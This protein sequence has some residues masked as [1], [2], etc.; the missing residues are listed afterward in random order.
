MTAEELAL[1]GYPGAAPA[2]DPASQP[3]VTG[4]D[5]SMLNQQPGSMPMQQ[6]GMMMPPGMDAATLSSFRGDQG[7]APAPQI[8]S[9]PNG[10]TTGPDQQAV[11]PDGQPLA[12]PPNT[13]AANTFGGAPASQQDQQTQSTSQPQPAPQANQ[14]NNGFPSF[15]EW[16]RASKLPQYVTPDMHKVM[17]EK[18]L[19]QQKDFQA[20]QDPEKLLKIQQLQHDISVAPMKDQNLQ[21]QTAESQSKVIAGELA[22]QNAMDTANG[23]I[24]ELQSQRDNLQAIANHPA[25]PSMVGAAGQYNPGLTDQQRNL[26]S[27]FDQIDGQKLIDGINKIK[28]ESSVP[29]SPLNFR[30]TQQ[31]ALAVKDSVNRLKRSQS[32][33]DYRNAISSYSSILDRAIAAKQAQVARMPGVN[34]DLLKQFSYSP[35][36]TS[37]ASVTGAA[38]SAAPVIKT[39]PGR[40]TYQSIGNGQWKQIQ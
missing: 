6:G 16:A 4:G 2:Q 7:N 34:Q 31:E 36:A 15:P 13:G 38:P 37:G 23:Q 10:L 40:G 33:D 12:L 3:A 25:L 19:D 30:I 17:V 27:Y 26:K 21:A 22:K 5:L 18:Y 8:T 29:G 1:L 35:A 28:N 32:L 9:D 11:G 14:S 39:I 20:R 24:S